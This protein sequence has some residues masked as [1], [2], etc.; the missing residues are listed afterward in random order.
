MIKSNTNLRPENTNTKFEN[1]KGD[2]HCHLSLRAKRESTM[3][4]ERRKNFVSI[5]LGMK[6]GV[7]KQTAAIATMYLKKIDRRNAKSIDSYRIS[8]EGEA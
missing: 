5:T 4:D 6:T 1:E 2:E 8:D 7:H 3:N